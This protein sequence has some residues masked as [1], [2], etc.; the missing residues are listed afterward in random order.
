MVATRR[1]LSWEPRL[2]GKIYCAPACGGGCTKAAYDKAVSDAAVLVS[3][4]CGKGWKSVVWE[5]LGWHYKAVSGPVQVYPAH[6]GLGDGPNTFWCMVGSSPKDSTGG[7]GFWTAQ[8]KQFKNPNRAVR[9]AMSYV[10]EFVDRVSRTVKA[11]EKAMG[12]LQ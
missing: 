3:K 11:A 7:A 4:L 12:V 5:N 6:R 1:P 10:Y 8:H 2:N 9:H